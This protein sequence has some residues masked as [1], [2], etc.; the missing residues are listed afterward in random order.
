MTKDRLNRNELAAYRCV[1]ISAIKTA[2][3]NASNS[4]IGALL[5]VSRETV[6]YHTRNG[7]KSVERVIPTSLRGDA[8]AVLPALDSGNFLRGAEMLEALAGSLRRLSQ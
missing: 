6:K 1:A 8:R 4:E 2:F 7:S 3:P 5:G